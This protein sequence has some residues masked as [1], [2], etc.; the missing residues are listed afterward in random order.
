MASLGIM[1]LEPVET[2]GVTGITY[3]RPACHVFIK[4]AVCGNDARIEAYENSS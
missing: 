4:Q 1:K 3:T 2:P